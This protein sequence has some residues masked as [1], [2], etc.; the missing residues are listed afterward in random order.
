MSEI[1]PPSPFP[2]NKIQVR[3]C[4]VPVNRLIRHEATQITE[5]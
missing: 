3:K 5:G 2:T 4:S 1:I